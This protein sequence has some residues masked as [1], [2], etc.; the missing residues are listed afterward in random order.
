VRAICH[1][2]ELDDT[3]L[4]CSFNET[5]EADD[6]ELPERNGRGAAS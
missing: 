4:F 5:M 6:A 2:D 1:L 3:D